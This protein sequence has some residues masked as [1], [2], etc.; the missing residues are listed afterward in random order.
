MLAH[1]H[2]AL[3]QC[4]PIT[5]SCATTAS[6][7]WPPGA[8]VRQRSLAA[9]VNLANLQAHLQRSG[10]VHAQGT[11]VRNTAFVGVT[12]FVRLRVSLVISSLS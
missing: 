11:S 12:V 9:Q 4:Q 3:P 6:L 2:I 8:Q 1:A 7:V 5:V 10:F